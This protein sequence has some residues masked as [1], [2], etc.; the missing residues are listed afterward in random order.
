MPEP[1]APA[2]PEGPLDPAEVAWLDGLRPG[3][4]VRML[5]Q[6]GWVHAQL[7]W[8]GERRKVWLFGDGASDAT[9]AV[10]RGALLKMHA[11]GLVKT[12]KVRSLVGSAAARVQEQMAA[13]GA[14]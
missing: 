3:Q 12:L 7:L 6:G 13:L 4:W 9:W 8:P 14:R 10:R 1:P 11:G 2:S 5:I